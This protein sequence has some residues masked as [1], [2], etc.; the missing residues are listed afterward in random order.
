M[1]DKIKTKRGE[2]FV[3]RLPSHGTAGYQWALSG[4]APDFVRLHKRSTKTAQPGMGATADEE[5]YLIS[6]EAGTFKV[7][8]ELKRPWESTAAKTHRVDVEVG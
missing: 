7:E 8:L 1:G 2:P 5:V 3:V 4:S 6:D